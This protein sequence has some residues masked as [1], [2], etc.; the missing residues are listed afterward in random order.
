[1]IYYKHHDFKIGPIIDERILYN[2]D[3]NKIHFKISILDLNPDFIRIIEKKDLMI[4]LIE[5]FKLDSVHKHWPIHIDGTSIKDNAKLNFVFGNF[6]SPMVWYK[7]KNQNTKQIKLTPIGS[8]YL[9]WE[10]DEVEEVDR[11][12]IQNG[13]IVQ[14]GH[15]HTSYLK[16]YAPRWILGLHFIKNFKPFTFDE[17]A[18]IFKEYEC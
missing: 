9:N 13:T 15:P 6:E 16:G 11:T 4:S 1:M 10:L 5:V 3:P 2:V 12:F 8:K 7:V 17:L 18:E 14:V